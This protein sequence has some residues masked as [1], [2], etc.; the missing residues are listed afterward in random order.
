VQKSSVRRKN[1]NALTATRRNAL[2]LASFRVSVGWS[3][4]L[5]AQPKTVEIAAINTFGARLANGG[6]IPAR[7]VLTPFMRSMKALIGRK[8]RTAVLLANK[9]KDP[10]PPL[11]SLASELKELG[12]QAI[13]DFMTPGNAPSVIQQKGMDAPLKGVGSDGGRLVAEFNAAVFKR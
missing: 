3:L 6:I 2:E 4:Q 8:H 12:K 13:R 5:G 9:G 1:P 10:R 7:D 11:E